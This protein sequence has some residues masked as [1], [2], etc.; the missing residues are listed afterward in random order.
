MTQ[1]ELNKVLELHKKW[2]NN[3]RGGKRADLYEADLYENDLHGADLRGIDLYGAYLH[4]ADLRGANLDFSCLPLCC[5]SF[6][7]EVDSRIAAQIAYH[8]CRLDCDDV[9]Y[10]NARNSIIEFANKFHRVDECGVLKKV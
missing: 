2:L 1:E 3:E 5:G 7:M 9:N 4:G 6:N 8:F 10:I